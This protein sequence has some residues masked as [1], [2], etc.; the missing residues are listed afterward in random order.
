MK[1][2][3]MF[4]LLIEFE[5]Y[6]ATESPSEVGGSFDSSGAFHGLNSDE[7]EL[8]SIHNSAYVFY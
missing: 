7:E 1:Y 2:W 8:V 6:R 4:Y 3:K 5:F